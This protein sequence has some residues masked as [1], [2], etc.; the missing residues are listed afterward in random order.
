MDFKL[1]AFMNIGIQE[2]MIAFLS[3]F[4]LATVYVSGPGSAIHF[5]VVAASA[6]AAD[7]L[8]NYFFYKKS[9][10]PKNAAITGLIVSLIMPPGSLLTSALVPAI[11]ILSKHIIRLGNM[12]LFNPAAFSLLLSSVILGVQT[13]WWSVSYLFSLPLGLFISY[14][15]RKLEISL[16]FMAAYMAMFYFSGISPLVELTGGA[17][18]FLAFFMMTE[19]KTTPHTTKGKYAFALLAA[20]L[21]LVFRSVT[22]VDYL[23]LSLLVSNIFTRYLN[24]LK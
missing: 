13:S 11:A 12:P 18:L 17:S 16:A 3:I 9:I 7:L 1:P 6:V 4:A 23:L 24:R 21:V 5:I 10:I 14:K 2:Y 22:S 15:I 8:I 19:P 20:A